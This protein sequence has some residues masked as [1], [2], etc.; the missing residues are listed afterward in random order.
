MEQKTLR[1]FEFETDD[2]QKIKKVPP[3]Y[4][5]WEQRQDYDRFLQGIWHR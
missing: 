1:L 4:S 3:L 5:K 2:P